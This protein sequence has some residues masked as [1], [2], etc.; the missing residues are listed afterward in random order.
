MIS[1]RLRQARLAAGLTQSQVIEKLQRLGVSLTK[2]GL[3]K[4]ENGRSIPVPQLL[5]KLGQVLGVVPKYF[6]KE[7][8]VSIQWLAFRKHAAFG[9]R[10]QD[11]I[12][13][14]AQEVVENQV[15][16]QEILQPGL[17]VHFP[18][19]RSAPILDDAESAAA[20]LRKQWSLGELP[21]ES[22]TSAIEDHGG[23]V[24]E[25]EGKEDEF[26]GLCGW[27]NGKYPLIVTSSSI[28]D[29][30]RR[31]SM[32]HELGHLSL[33]REG[34]AEDKQEQWAHRFAA[35]F[36]VP[37]SAARM[38]LGERRRRLSLEELVILK[39][40]YGMGVKAWMRRALE[41]EIIDAGHFRS[42][43]AQ[44]RRAQWAGKESLIPRG[45]EHPTRLKQMTL[46]ALTEGLITPEKA[47][48]LCPGC[49][50]EHRGDEYQQLDEILALMNLP[51]DEKGERFAE[52][53]REVEACYRSDKELTAFEAFSDEDLLD[54]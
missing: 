15:W 45:K 11:G 38:E 53:A 20:A 40:K 34:R 47:Q 51:E 9:K 4:Y 52:M 48:E 32:A 43:E 37:A 26:G 23:I 35:A 49:I 3:S 25:C 5:F 44:L 16:L 18:V 13:A 14:A 24:V 27:V 31:F 39:R 10:R 22:V 21:I 54:E 41:L 6:L 12:K 50:G 2:G 28:S 1:L 36:I 7:P 30:R 33:E 19:R 17:K 46:R 42:L 29:E 8:T